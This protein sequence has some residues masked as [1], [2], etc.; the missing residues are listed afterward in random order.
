[1]QSLTSGTTTLVQGLRKAFAG[2]ESKKF[3]K[4]M[5][6]INNTIA[7]GQAA[8]TIINPLMTL[9]SVVAGTATAETLALNAAMLANPV[10]WIVGGI[11]AL[12]GA[13]KLYQAIADS[14]ANR[15]IENM[16]TALENSE[17][18]IKDIENNLSNLA[19]NEYF[20]NIASQID[21]ME[22]QAS[23]AQRQ[24]SAENS[25]TKPDEDKVKEYTE[26]VEEYTQTARDKQ[27]AL[28][29]SLWGTLNQ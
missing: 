8:Y 22:K 7:I 29:E 15:E 5:E 19:G 26:S 17:R 9:Y 6:E 21:E 13:L 10:F 4:V 20:Q 11:M 14:A 28:I 1:M 18:I 3:A 2:K 24:L 16:N 23:Y 27:R 12:V 25:K